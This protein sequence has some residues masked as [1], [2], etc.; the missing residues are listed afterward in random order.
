MAGERSRERRN[1]LPAEKHN[2]MQSCIR[3]LA[4][5][6]G[7]QDHQLGAIR[8]QAMSLNTS[9]GDGE[10]TVLGVIAYRSGHTFPFPETCI[11]SDWWEGHA[12]V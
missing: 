4:H 7:I 2:P 1:Q 8:H 10:K 6:E 11:K 9:Y 5:F 12:C 3:L